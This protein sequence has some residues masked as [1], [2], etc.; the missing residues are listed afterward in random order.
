[1]QRAREPFVSSLDTIP[2]CHAVAGLNEWLRQFAASD[3]R[4]G[5]S[6]T[7]QL[8]LETWVLTRPRVPFP[9]V[10]HRRA[11]CRDA[12]PSHPASPPRSARCQRGSGRS[13]PLA[14]TG[15]FMQT[16]GFPGADLLVPY[17]GEYSQGCFRSKNSGTSMLSASIS[18]ICAFSSGG[19]SLRSPSRAATSEVKYNAMV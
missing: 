12:S 13:R 11:G 18:S 7:Y 5:A 8:D 6:V 3:Q 1:M 14:V 16:I 17:R 15:S 4:A 10:E 19:G 2:A 9:A